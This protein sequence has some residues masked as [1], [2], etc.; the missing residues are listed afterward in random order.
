MSDYNNLNE[1]KQSGEEESSKKKVGFHRFAYYNLNKK[2][3]YSMNITEY[4]TKIRKRI[5]ELKE[6]KKSAIEG[7]R[8]KEVE[9]QIAKLKG[10]L[11]NNADNAVFNYLM[12]HV[13]SNNNINMN[14]IQ[15]NQSAIAKE[16]YLNR[17]TVSASFNKL[18]RLHII[19]YNTQGNAF[20]WIRI[21][22]FICWQGEANSHYHKIQE[23]KDFARRP[24]EKQE[25][26]INSQE[27][28]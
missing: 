8:K 5:T 12:A 7:D 28:V 15:K 6:E 27:A 16:L 18:K 14:Q 11:I 10:D 24:F 13:Q 1:K 4:E 26:V 17:Q 19:S 9:K 2:E 3:G 25:D 20:E 23:Q 21:S 22:P